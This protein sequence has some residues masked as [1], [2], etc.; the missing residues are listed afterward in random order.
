MGLMINSRIELFNPD[1]EIAARLMQ[2]WRVAK[3]YSK[4]RKIS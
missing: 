4:R 1:Q 2:E 3:H